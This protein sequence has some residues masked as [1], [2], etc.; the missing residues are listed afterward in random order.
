[1]EGREDLHDAS[2]GVVI[3]QT[4]HHAA[5][6]EGAVG[7]GQDAE[8]AGGGLGFTTTPGLGTVGEDGR[9]GDG[10]GGPWSQAAPLY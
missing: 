4:G 6:V 1:M 10:L 8:D 3:R 7:D 9:A 2:H 5:E